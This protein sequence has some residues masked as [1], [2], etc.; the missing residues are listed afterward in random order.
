MTNRRKNELKQELRKSE[1]RGD[2]SKDELR[3][4][5]DNPAEIEYSFDELLEAFIEDCEFRNLRE[6]T[7]K[8]YRSELTT[9]K[10]ILHEQGLDTSPYE[11]TN[12][13]I[14]HNVIMYMKNKGIK[15]V[16]INSRLRAIRAFF[17]FLESHNYIKI[18]PMKNIKLLKD[19][20][21]IVETFDMK[22]IKALLNACDIRTFVGFRDRTIMLFLL[23]TGVR[24]NELIGIKV[25]DIIWSQKIVRIRNTKG[26]YERF[27]PVQNKMI[28]QLKKYV[29]IR[30]QVDTDYLFITQD[31]TPMSK[32]QV[33]NRI[34][35]YGEMAK[36]KNV[37]CSPH[38]FRHTFAKLSVMN[39]ANAFQLQAILGHSTM[40]VT[41]M[42][43]N[44][45]SN[46]IQ[47]GHAKFSPLKNL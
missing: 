13:I 5:L 36:I 21:R 9:F 4:V 22:Q 32:R 28:D 29:T 40:E 39:G 33:Q 18:N 37:R 12:E 8:F 26:G 44:L 45:F 1:R 23:E 3:F 35:H 11:I 34:K 20:K 17:N 42:Y 25:T 7:I 16:S 6:H 27:V 24:V 2:L 30:G 15:A 46:E 38:T 10:N 43:V 19:R 47:E 31:N 14:K 41:K